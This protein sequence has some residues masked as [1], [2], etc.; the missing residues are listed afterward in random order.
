M[1]KTFGLT[2]IFIFSQSATAVTF[3]TD[4]KKDTTYGA[5]E[6]DDEFSADGLGKHFVVG[7]IP[8]P[9]EVNGK[10][11]R[12]VDVEDSTFNCKFAFK[13]ADPKLTVGDKFYVFQ[14]NKRLVTN[15]SGR[16]IL[17]AGFELIRS[18]TDGS[19]PT[20]S[21]KYLCGID[22]TGKL[23]YDE[24]TLISGFVTYFRSI[25]AIKKNLP[26]TASSSRDNH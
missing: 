23:G 20:D 15:S 5:P 21:I 9:K 6:I 16:T 25:N 3:I 13:T 26:S 14:S 24:G 10:F 1:F 18:G 8:T 11:Y 4:L 19:K 17:M 22:V 2:L 7:H 12:N